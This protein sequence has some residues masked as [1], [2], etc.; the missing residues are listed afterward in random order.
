VAA[1]EGGLAPGVT[2]GLDEAGALAGAGPAA[3]LDEAD[4]RD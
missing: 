2:G 1:G 4:T 3:A